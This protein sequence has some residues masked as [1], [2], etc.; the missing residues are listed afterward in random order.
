MCSLSFFHTINCKIYFFIDE[1]LKVTRLKI[2]LLTYAVG[3]HR[4]VL[5]YI[6]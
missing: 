2:I 3:F 5:C 4:V 6:T 1:K